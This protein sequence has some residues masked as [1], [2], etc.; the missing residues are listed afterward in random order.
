MF[1]SKKVWRVFLSFLFLFSLVF[2]I[3]SDHENADKTR[4]IGWESTLAIVNNTPSD[5]KLTL[6]SDQ[7]E[8][9]NVGANS[10][11]KFNFKKGVY[12]WVAYNVKTNKVISSGVVDLSET[13]RK[14]IITIKK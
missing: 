13:N 1:K 12:S 2:F 10:E 8:E 14:A 11:M 6:T 9:I 5:I 3:A 4:C 7:T